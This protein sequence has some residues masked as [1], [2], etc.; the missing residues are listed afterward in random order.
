MRAIELEEKSYTLEAK[1]M[2]RSMP[3][4]EGSIISYVDGDARIALACMPA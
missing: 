4:S 3:K 1:C 2:Y